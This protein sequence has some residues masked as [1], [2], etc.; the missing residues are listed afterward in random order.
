MRTPTSIRDDISADDLRR[1]AKVSDDVVARR[2]L[3]IAHVLDGMSHTEVARKVGTSLSSMASWIRML[4]VEGVDGLQGLRIGRVCSIPIREDISADDL[5]Q[6][7]DVGL[8]VR[9]ERADRNRI[10]SAEFEGVWKVKL[11]CSALEMT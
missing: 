7:A 9:P 2:F 11:P 4:N 8:P 3:A 1:A 10:A 6:A 5:Q